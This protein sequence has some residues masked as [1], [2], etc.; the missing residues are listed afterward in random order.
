MDLHRLVL[1]TYFAFYL[2]KIKN[3]NKIKDKYTSTRVMYID[4]NH[5]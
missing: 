4:E 3:K 1:L 2:N 5:A